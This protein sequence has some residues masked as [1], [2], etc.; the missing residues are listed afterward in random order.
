VNAQLGL[1]PEKAV[2]LNSPVDVSKVY[3]DISDEITVIPSDC[4]SV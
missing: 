1:V 3:G 2:I 4:K